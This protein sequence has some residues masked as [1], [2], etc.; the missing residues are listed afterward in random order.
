MLA[1][2]LQL[3]KNVGQQQSKP[4][5][6]RLWW[7]VRWPAARVLSLDPLRLWDLWGAGAPTGY[8]IRSVDQT[9]C[10]NLVHQRST[11][12]GTFHIYGNN[13]RSTF[14]HDREIFPSIFWL[15][16]R[17][18]GGFVDQGRE[19]DP[20]PAWSWISLLGQLLVDE[21]YKMLRGQ[22]D[23]GTLWLNQ[24]WSAL[25]PQWLHAALL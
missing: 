5:R 11:E 13:D 1:C 19:V 20:M 6:P 25:P 7:P 12:S 9:D 24:D 14:S 10:F 16:Q 3:R 22:L 15:V 8:S 18:P 17:H 23:W 2:L 4:R 21:F